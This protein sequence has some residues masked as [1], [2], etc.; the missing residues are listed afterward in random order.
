MMK[1]GLKMMG[2]GMDMKMMRKK[3]FLVMQ[4][5]HRRCSRTRK[6]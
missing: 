6:R 4:R 2:T 1:K 5:R 3:R